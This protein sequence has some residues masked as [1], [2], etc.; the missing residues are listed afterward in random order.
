MPL[1]AAPV[2]H[3]GENSRTT[4]RAGGAAQTGTD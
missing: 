4:I 3:I 2:P 1:S